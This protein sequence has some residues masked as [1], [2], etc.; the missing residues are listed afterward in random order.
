MLIVLLF[1]STFLLAYFNGANDNFKG[2]ATL[3]GSRTLPFKKAITL[4]TIM[5][6]LGS[7]TAIY[8]ANGLLSHFSGKGFVP[9][10]ITDSP[11]FLTS[12]SFGAGLTLF[13]ATRLGFPISTTHSLVGGLMGAGY[14]AVGPL[15]NFEKMGAV[16]LLPLIL[17]P[18]LALFLA[19][20]IYWSLTHIRKKLQL[21]KKKSR[22]G[23]KTEPKVM[24]V[25]GRKKKQK[26]YTDRIGRFSLQNLLDL[27]H[28]LSGAAVSFARGLN[29]TPKFAALLLI[30]PSITHSMSYLI[31]GSAM[32]IGGWFHSKRI[33]KTMGKRIIAINHGQGLSANI[34][35]SFLVLIATQFGLSVSTTHVS[36]G[37]LFGIGFV[38]K[39]QDSKT[40]KRILWS[41][42]ITLPLAMLLAGLAYYLLEKM[43]F[44]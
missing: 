4:A 2:V 15:V 17:S 35:T 37:S 42:V 6:L 9:V 5:T 31:I 20:L 18:I 12:V 11:Q 19:M 27:A 36:V 10:G 8:L 33:A 1:L 14:M 16:F 32:G 40:I 24:A 38:T 26:I 7:V 21:T 23:R 43:H 3:Y 28:T 29:D 30:I 22:R 13:M 34:A 41:W 25:F 39:N 44:Q